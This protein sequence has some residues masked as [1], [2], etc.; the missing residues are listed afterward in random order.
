MFFWWILYSK[1][2]DKSKYVYR[3]YGIGLDGKGKWNFGNDPVRN[4]IIFGVDNTSL[5]NTDNR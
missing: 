5:S 4:V 1:N 3:G 2:S